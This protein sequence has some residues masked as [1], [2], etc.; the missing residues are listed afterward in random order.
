MCGHHGKFRIRRQETGKEWEKLFMVKSDK[1]ARIGRGK[2]ENG[3][4][5]R[6]RKK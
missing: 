1:I 3:D 4:G 5:G 6:K 2:K